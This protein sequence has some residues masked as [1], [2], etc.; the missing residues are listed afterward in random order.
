MNWTAMI[1]QHD[2]GTCKNNEITGISHHAL[3]EPDV[4]Y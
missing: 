4:T 3:T 1:T 2:R